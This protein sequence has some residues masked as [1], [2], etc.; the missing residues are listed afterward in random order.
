VADEGGS[1]QVASAETPTDDDRQRY[2]RLLDSAYSRRL[3][4][5]SE[6]SRR[7]EELVEADSIERM[8]QIVG[9][10]PTGLDPVDM[11]RLTGPRKQPNPAAK[12]RQTAIIAIVF[13]FLMLIILGVLLAVSVHNHQSG[14]GALTAVLGVAVAARSVGG[15]FGI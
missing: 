8:D 3:I 12:R 2:G 10:I 9:V 15:I 11:A 5:D 7:L 13:L 4:D 14:L 6:Y 1:E